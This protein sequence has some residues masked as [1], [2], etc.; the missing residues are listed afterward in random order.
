M[1]IYLKADINIQRTKEKGERIKEKVDLRQAQGFRQHRRY[2]T[3]NGSL[4]S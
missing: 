2:F 3:W 4:F 1:I